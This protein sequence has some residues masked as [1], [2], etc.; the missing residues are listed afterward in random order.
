MQSLQ[1][2]LELL[3]IANVVLLAP[4]P[5]MAQRDPIRLT[6]GPM[7]G[8]P[9]AHSVLVW[10][11]T[12]DP[13]EFTVHYGTDA[14][15][16]D[17]I[18]RPAVTTIE[19]DCTG[20]ATLSDLKPDAHYHYQL[21]VNGRPHGLPGRFRTLPSADVVRNAAHNPRGLFN[22]RFEIGSCANQ[23]PL[24]GLG[25]RTPTYCL[26]PQFSSG[27]VRGRRGEHHEF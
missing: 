24:N 25:H 13:G 17:Q 3:A 9:T 20:I 11:R 5:A 15:R 6:H 16:L 23:N 21:W 8:R 26:I 18:S 22:F 4:P 10:G 14:E 2:A 19:H 7:L 27:R 1:R 12:S